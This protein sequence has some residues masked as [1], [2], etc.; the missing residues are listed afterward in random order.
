MQ[1]RTRRIRAQGT[2]AEIEVFDGLPH[3]FGLGEGT[4]RV[5]SITPWLSGNGRCDERW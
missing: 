4:R 2:D 1:E 5:G 3:G